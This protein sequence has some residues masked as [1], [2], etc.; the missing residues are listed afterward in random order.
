MREAGIVHHLRAQTHRHSDKRP[1]VSSVTSVPFPVD[2]RGTADGRLIE[3]SSSLYHQS[4]QP[5]YHLRSIQSACRN[6]EKT[7]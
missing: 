2:E 6:K 1:S 3:R 5:V 4:F 7:I